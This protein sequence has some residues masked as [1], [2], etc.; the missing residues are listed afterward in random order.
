MNVKQQC[1]EVKAD[2]VFNNGN[3]NADDFSYLLHL[4]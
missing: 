4:W 3:T 2:D 1:L